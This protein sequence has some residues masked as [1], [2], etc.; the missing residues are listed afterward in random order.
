M[1]SSLTCCLT[2]GLWTRTVLPGTAGEDS[3]LLQ[4]DTVSL[5][6]QH[7]FRRNVWPS[8]SRVH[9]PWRIQNGLSTSCAVVAGGEGGSGWSLIGGPRGSWWVQNSGMGK[10]TRWNET[11]HSTES[12]RD[13]QTKHMKLAQSVAVQF[14]CHLLHQRHLRNKAPLYMIHLQH[15]EH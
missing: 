14:Q 6:K 4:C 2:V 8:S 10:E 9:G 13:H 5:V 11:M 1:G 15:C 7:I 12:S 3:G